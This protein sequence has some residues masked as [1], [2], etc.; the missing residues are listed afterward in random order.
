MNAPEDPARDLVRRS[1]R[2]QKRH[3]ASLLLPFFGLFLLL[4]PLITLFNVEARPAGIPA[5]FVY[6]Y[7]IW[8]GLIFLAYRLRPRAED[9]D[10]D[11]GT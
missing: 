7:A 1:Q 3:D 5:L 10:G 11:A 6:V 8:A 4:S 2:A 9:E